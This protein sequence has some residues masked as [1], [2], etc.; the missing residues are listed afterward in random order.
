MISVDLESD[1]DFAIKLC[2]YDM[3]EKITIEGL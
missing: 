1:F 3:P 2:I